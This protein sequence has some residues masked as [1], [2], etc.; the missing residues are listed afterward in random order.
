MMPKSDPTLTFNEVAV[1][2]VWEVQ[3]GSLN[4]YLLRGFKQSSDVWKWLFHGN[5]VGP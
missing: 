1:D 5:S 3:I 2:H 4:S